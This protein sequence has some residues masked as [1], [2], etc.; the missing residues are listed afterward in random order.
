MQFTYAA[1]AGLPAGVPSGSGS[2]TWTR[3]TQLNGL[4]CQ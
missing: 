4:T 1:N 3:A 2:K